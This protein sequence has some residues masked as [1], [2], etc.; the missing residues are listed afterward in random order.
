ML[1]FVSYLKHNITEMKK[2]LL[3]LYSLLFIIACGGG[4]DAGGGSGPSASSEYLNVSDVDIPG[5][6]TSATMSIQASA[7]CEWS[8]AWSDSWIRSVSPSKGRGGQNVTITVDVNPSPTA[9]RTAL[10][11]ITN[12]NGSI[13][14]KVSISQSASAERLTIS[15]ATDGKLTFPSNS[16]GK[17]YKIT[18]SSNTHWTVQGIPSW[19]SVSPREGNNDGD[20]SITASPNQTK[21]V[22]N[23]TLVFRGDGGSS[24][25]VVVTQESASLPVVTKPKV[26]EFGKNTATITF[27]FT[28]EATVTAYGICYDTKENPNLDTGQNEPKTGS[29]T[30]A[31]QTIQLKNLSSGTTYYIR[32]Y[33]TSAVGTQYSDQ[34]SFTTTS[35]WPENEDNPTPDS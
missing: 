18:V 33:A 1:A 7:N 16:S 32:A 4:D 28:S 19:L 9:T 20:V 11:T 21:D 29:E 30:Q 14:R 25:E 13:T 3:L 12:S 35:S 23:A 17:E 26:V 8:I 22:L 15:G 5:A 24:A 27:T 10:L 31:E 6:N 34:E 2:L